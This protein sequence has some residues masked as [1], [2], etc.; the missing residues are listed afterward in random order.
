MRA[1]GLYI[2]ALHE[3]GIDNP[4]NRIAVVASA[5]G[6]PL[7]ALLLKNSPLTDEDC[8][9]IQDFADRMGFHVWALPGRSFDTMQSRY[10]RATASQRATFLAQAPLNLSPTS[11]DNP[12]YYNYYRWRNLGKNLGQIDVG[13]NLA[14][15]QIVLATIL[16][17]AIVSSVLLILLPLFVFRRHGLRTE[18]KWGFIAF[19]LG[20]GTGFMFIEISFIQKFVLF[21]GY[22]TYSLTVVLFSLL[23]YSGIGSLLSGRMRRP[24]E[25]RLLPLLACLTAVSLSYLAVLPPL[26]HAFLGSPFA[27]RVFIA[28][29][30]LVPLGL[31]M[32]MFFPSGIHIVRRANLNFVPWA[33]GI[34]GC[35]SVVATVLAVMLAMSY[36][37]RVVTL[38]ALASYLAGVLG[39]RAS[40]T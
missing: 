21:L 22:P 27:L 32:G 20:I 40:A 9:R 1:L 8:T 31:V 35:A 7:V 18:G 3:R 33:W 2:E 19:F 4:Q 39:M 30:V 28:S 16:L 25:Q 29:A 14:T 24:P 10:L 13:H 36:G 5:E 12:F 6:I 15:G 23:T 26:F 17:V 34:N 37:F 38:L 11:D